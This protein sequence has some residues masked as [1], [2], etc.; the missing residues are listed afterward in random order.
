MAKTDMRQSLLE[1][2]GVKVEH[3]KNGT[4]RVRLKAYRWALS[5]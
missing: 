2:E 4:A 1:A 3:G 5:L